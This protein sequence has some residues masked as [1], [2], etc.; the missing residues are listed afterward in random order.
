M[1]NKTNQL[2][3][4]IDELVFN[5]DV[6]DKGEINSLKKRL[7]QFAHDLLDEVEVEDDKSHTVDYTK[8]SGMAIQ[9][10]DF[11]RGY[12]QANAQWREKKEEVLR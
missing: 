4:R 9:I 3:Q 10:S 5:V 6:H 12:N 1:K 7:R 2:D 11:V 8:D